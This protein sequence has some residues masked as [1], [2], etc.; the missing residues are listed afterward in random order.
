[1]LH[2]LVVFLFLALGVMAVT[3]L[4][5]RGYRRLREVRPLLAGAWGVGLAWLANLNMGTGWDVA[6]LRRRRDTYRRR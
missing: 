5:E 2:F 6:H 4:G 3:A 1:M